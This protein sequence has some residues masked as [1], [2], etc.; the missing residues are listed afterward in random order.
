[1]SELITSNINQYVEI[2]EQRARGLLPEMGSA[3]RLCEVMKEH[4]VDQSPFTLMDI[5]CATGHYFKSFASRSGTP[6]KYTG[7][8]IDQHMIAAAKRVWRH[9]VQ[10]GAMDFECGNP[11][12]LPRSD[13]PTVDHIICMNAFMY[14]VSAERALEYM[15][16]HAR[17]SIVIRGYFADNS[18]KIMRSQTSANHDSSSVREEDS[19]DREGNL[20]C[21]DLWNIYS[22]AYIKGLVNKI[23]S[24]DFSVGWVEDKNNQK[25]IAE[26]VNLGLEKRGSTQL[27]AGHE[28]SYPIIQPWKY[29][30]LSRV[31]G[32]SN[33]S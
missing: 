21:Y 2:M 28:V 32:H 11:E 33:Q 10:S 26:E 25:S 8:D 9:E 4:G 13:S 15:I 3:I 19:I 16:S 24:D 27:I 6:T 31:S 7:I 18:F 22:Y 12:D 30:V 5:G 17:K 23:C 14:F 1:M 20:K 29:L